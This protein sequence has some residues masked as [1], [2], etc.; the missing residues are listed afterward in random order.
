MPA[1]LR[2]GPA[3][4]NEF[5]PVQALDLQPRAPIRLVPAID[6]LRDDA[7]QAALA[8]KPMEV[9]ATADLMIVVL[10]RGRCA[11]QQRFQPGL[12]VEEGQPGHVLAVN[13]QEIEHEVDE[14]ALSG[15]AGILDQVERRPAIRQHAAEFAIQVGV[16]GPPRRVRI[17]S[18][19]ASSR[20]C[21]RYPSSLI[22]CSQSGPSGAALTSAASCGFTQVGKDARST[23]EYDPRSTK[24]PA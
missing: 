8:G 12:A 19:P 22:S 2:V 5:L 13:E 23:I 20:A 1:A 16:L 17:C 10:E 21:M 24:F 7:F 6:A 3:N 9:R 18:R 11:S 15:V 4:Y 14:R